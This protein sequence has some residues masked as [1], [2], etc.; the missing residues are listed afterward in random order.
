MQPWKDLGEYKDTTEQ[1]LHSMFLEDT[2][3]HFMDSGG[4][5]GRHHQQNQRKTLDDFRKNPERVLH[6]YEGKYDNAWLR[7]R[8]LEGDKYLELDYIT[9][10]TFSGLY[11]S[12]AYDEDLDKELQEYINTPENRGEGNYGLAMDWLIDVK[13]VPEKL[14]ES[15][16]SYNFDTNLTQTFQWVNVKDSDLILLQVHGGGDVRGGY[17]DPRVFRITDKDKFMNLINGNYDPM[18][19][20]GTKADEEF[21]KRVGYFLTVATDNH[22]NYYKDEYDWDEL[23]SVEGQDTPYMIKDFIN[24]FGHMFDE[25]EFEA[26]RDV[27]KDEFRNEDKKKSFSDDDYE[28][29]LLDQKFY[30]QYKKKDRFK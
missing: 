28:T 10:D 23:D 19:G 30:G 24:D 2:G 15:D 6:F 12:L 4:D 3:E 7:E 20:I 11:D 21:K 18:M 25:D 14:V 26:F 8:N 29:K 13:G 1:I 27:Y 22:K 17:T 16:N 9:K 5:F